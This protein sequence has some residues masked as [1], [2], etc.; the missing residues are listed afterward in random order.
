MEPEIKTEPSSQAVSEPVQ[1]LIVPNFNKNHSFKKLVI[2]LLVILV[3]FL[4]AA[5]VFF[6]TQQRPGKPK[7]TP[8]ATPT[9]TSAVSELPEEIDSATATLEVQSVSDEVTDIEND[10]NDT[11][12]TDIDKE[13]TDIETELSL[14]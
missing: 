14:P 9:P 12:L 10:L 3:V 7:S 13:L 1:E 4:L 11:S 8:L 6:V 5:S 2:L